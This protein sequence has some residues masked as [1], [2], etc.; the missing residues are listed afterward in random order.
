MSTNPRIA[1]V[2]DVAAIRNSLKAL[3][4]TEP[5]PDH[6]TVRRWLSSNICRCTGYLPI[7]EAVER[8]KELMVAPPSTGSR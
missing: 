3:L 4:E 2:D 8:A 7:F 1:V 6:E 5:D